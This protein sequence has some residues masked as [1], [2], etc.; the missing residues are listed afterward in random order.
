MRKNR[1]YFVWDYD[2]SEEDVRNMLA[3]DNEIEVDWAITRIL[4]YADWKDI[5]K[6]LSLNLI[7][8]HIDHLPMRSH[9]L[10]EHWRYSLKRWNVTT[11][12]TY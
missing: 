9:S 1:P 6:Y 11:Q 4:E 5:W 2:Y 10:K 3:S 7:A 8:Q 12:K